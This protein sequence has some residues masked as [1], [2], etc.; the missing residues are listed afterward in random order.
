MAQTLLPAQKGDVL[1]LDELWSFVGSKAWGICWVWLAL[2]RRTR[3]VVAFSLGDRS[4]EGARHLRE[5]IPKAYRRRA[6]RSDQWQPYAL[7]FGR[8]THRLC[9]KKQGQTNHAESF[10]GA[11]R[12]R[13]SRLVRRARS[14]SK[15]FDHH[16][17]W[18]RLFFT[19]HNLRL[20]PA[21]QQ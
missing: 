11:L 12:Q 3:Q 7:A 9:K 19:H 18:L 6:T 5:Q 14:F 8:R 16:E 1:E 21:L 13:A 10:W 15:R 4:E 17:L 20:N 2:C